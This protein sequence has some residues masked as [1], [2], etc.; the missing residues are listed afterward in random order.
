MDLHEIALVV[1][2]IGFPAIFCFLLWR[3]IENHGD[4]ELQVL[5]RMCVKLDRIDRKLT[6]P[7]RRK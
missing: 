4:K 3:Y 6:R 7:R 2:D 5:N 1:A